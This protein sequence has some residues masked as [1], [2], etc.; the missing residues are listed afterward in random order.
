M[1]KMA[2][3]Y[4]HIRLD[5]NQIFYIGIEL[6]TEKQKAKGLRPKTKVGRNKFWNNIVN[7]TEYKIEIIKDNLTNQEAK[8]LEI[9]LISFYGRRDL[10]QGFLVNLTNGG[11]GT[12]GCKPSK[13]TKAK[14]SE[15]LKG[16]N[17]GRVS[18]MKGKKNPNTSKK[19]K[20]NY[21]YNNRI[22]KGINNVNAKQVININTK[23]IWD[24]IVDCAVE[25][26]INKSTLTAWLSGQ[27]K[28]KSDFRYL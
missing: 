18:P 4:Q 12:N 15:A 16:K 2:L 25:N 14:I 17:I 21:F 20:S 9:R 3:V 26:N 28:N 5:T 11:D 1:N 6:D 24:C 23:Q 27:N 10:N 13:K 22:N 8:Y 7:K 19:G